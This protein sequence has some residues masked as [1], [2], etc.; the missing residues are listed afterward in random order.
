MGLWKR[1]VA[2][3]TCSDEGHVV[4]SHNVVG[5][6]LAG[7]NID[8]DGA[9]I[10]RN[11]RARGGRIRGSDIRCGRVVALNIVC[12]G[13]LSINGD[14]IHIDGVHFRLQDMVKGPPMLLIDAVVYEP[15]TTYPPPLPDRAYPPWSGTLN[16]HVIDVSTTMIT[17]DG[18]EYRAR[19][20]G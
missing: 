1:F 20:P 11:L 12:Q 5:G 4:Q 9:R 16:G 8:L 19:Q 10:G 6:N 7:G 15:W 18:V 2:W 3:L 13:N 14:G 17:V